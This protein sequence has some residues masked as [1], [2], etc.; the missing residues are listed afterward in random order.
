M[1][2]VNQQTFAKEVLK[3]QKPVI[4]NFWAPWCGLCSLINPILLKFQS[5]DQEHFVKLVSINADENL[6]LSNTYRL[7]NL[8]TLL[9]FVQGDIIQRLDSFQSREDLHRHLEQMMNFLGSFQSHTSE[10]KYNNPSYS[11]KRDS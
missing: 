3:A 5:P 1:I 2:S 7:K 8:P 11:K 6:Q 9:V 10:Q 4:V